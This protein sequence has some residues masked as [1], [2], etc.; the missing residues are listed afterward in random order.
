MN[1]VPR[2]PVDSLNGHTTYVEEH[3]YLLHDRHRAFVICA[4]YNMLRTVVVG[5]LVRHDGKLGPWIWIDKQRARDGSIQVCYKEL[6]PNGV[7]CIERARPK[8]HPPADDAPPTGLEGET[9]KP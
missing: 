8:P 3:K 6:T 9:V 1:S 7:A 5:R 4:E 2:I